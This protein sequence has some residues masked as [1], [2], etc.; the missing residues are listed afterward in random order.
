MLARTEFDSALADEESLHSDESCP[1]CGH[2]PAETP[3]AMHSRF[4]R[5]LIERTGNFGAIKWL[6][7]P[8]WQNVLDLWTL[9]ETI[10][11]VRPSLLIECGTN[12][13]GSSLFFAHLFDLMGQGEIVTIDIE[14]LH[15]LSHS[16]ITSLIGSSISPEILDQVRGKAAN[17]RGPV[18]VTLDSDH[19]KDHVFRELDHYAPLVTPGSYC[20]VQ[21]GVID[22]LPIFAAGRPGPLRAIEQFLESNDE[23]EIDRERSERFLISH[24]PCGWLRRRA[25]SK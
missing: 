11:E 13:G 9:Q 21:D 10:V 25:A 2:D 5:D 18:M 6:G 19:S 16:R 23:F 7:Q 3:S 22:T 24:H 8:I 15:N 14:R 4:F 12:R 1:H 20:L 17:S